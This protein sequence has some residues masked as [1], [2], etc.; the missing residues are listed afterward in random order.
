M[1]LLH[2]YA[3][4]AEALSLPETWLRR[5]INRIPHEKYGKYVRFGPEHLEA[6]R[7]MHQVLPAARPACGPTNLVPRGAR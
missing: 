1:T 4:A 7:A 5:N 6:I 3:G 2:D